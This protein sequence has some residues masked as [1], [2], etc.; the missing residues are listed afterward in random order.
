MKET[1]LKKVQEKREG[2]RTKLNS[3]KYNF[4]LAFKRA[5]SGKYAENLDLIL[6]GGV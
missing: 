3:T 6:K 5:I 4:K 2:N 1:R